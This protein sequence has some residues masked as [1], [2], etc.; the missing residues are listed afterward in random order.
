MIEGISY[1]VFVLRV[2]VFNQ[3][4]LHSYYDHALTLLLYSSC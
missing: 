1:D 4:I 3:Q 2:I